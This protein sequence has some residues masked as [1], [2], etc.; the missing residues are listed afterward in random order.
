MN[1]WKQSIERGKDQ[2]NHNLMIFLEARMNVCHNLLSEMLQALSKVDPKL[3]EYYIKL[4]SILRSLS[5]C[6]T[7]SKV[8]VDSFGKHTV[9]DQECS[10]R[11]MR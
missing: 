10:I 1:E 8:Y 4:V 2:H 5:A 3:M 6:N 11:R 9:A 7:R